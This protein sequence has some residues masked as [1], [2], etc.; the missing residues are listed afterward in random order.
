[1]RIPSVESSRFPGEGSSAL[2]KSG[3]KGSPKGVPDG[4]LVY[5]PELLNRLKERR[6]RQ[7]RTDKWISV[8]IP[9]LADRK[10]RLRDVRY[11]GNAIPSQ[12]SKKN[13]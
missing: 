7:D 2:G 4:Y 6:R 3:P 11:R 1:M 13:F 10:N 12:T 5:N 8:K 9:R